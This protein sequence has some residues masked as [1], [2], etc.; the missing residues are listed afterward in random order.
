MPSAFRLLRTA[1]G[2]LKQHWKLFLGIIAIYGLLN[3]ILVEGISGAGDPSTIKDA[4]HQGLSG[5]FGQFASG[6]SV[7]VYLL[8]T[9]ASN[10]TPG[11]GTYQFILTL[12]VSL[13]L[14][15]ALREVYAGHKVRIRDS[16]YRGMYPF[17]PFLLVCCVVLIQCIPFA[18]GAYLYSTVTANGVAATSLETVL[19]GVIFALLALTTLY[20]LASS[21]IALYI[22]TLQDMEPMAALKAA[23][24]LVRNQRWAVLRRVVFL[25]I[26]LVLLSAA[27]IIPSILFATVFAQFIFFAVTTVFVAVLHS[28]MYALYRSL[29]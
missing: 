5:H 21:I 14:I 16:Y 11:S 18:I 12:T 24:D 2:T 29:L 25:P 27:I 10:G 15:W 1:L 6:A 22:V 17:V 26:A 4:L 19:W 9:S 7:F 20:M 23:R 3:I 28:Y 8:G 13:A